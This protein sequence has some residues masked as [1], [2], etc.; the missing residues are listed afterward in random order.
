MLIFGLNWA[1]IVTFAFEG[2]E[3]SFALSP[4]VRSR[5]LL[6]LILK[7]DVEILL[8]LCLIEICEVHQKLS[9]EIKFKSYKM[10]FLS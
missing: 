6:V 8:V 10:N 2:V 9:I 5:K 3:H 4:A 1:L 7:G